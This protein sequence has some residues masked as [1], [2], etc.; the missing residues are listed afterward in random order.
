ML[1][2]RLAQ[3]STTD[4]DH[5]KWSQM[6]SITQAGEKDFSEESACQKLEIWGTESYDKFKA[7]VMCILQK[8]LRALSSGGDI[9]GY[10][11]IW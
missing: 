8:K 5:V 4:L 6:G 10:F 11:I 9:L 2:K 7:F 3:R 1:D